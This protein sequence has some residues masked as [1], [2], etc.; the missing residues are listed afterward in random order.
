MN[1][2]HKTRD[3]LYIA[4]VLAIVGCSNSGDP[5]ITGVVSYEGK[6]I[7]SGVINFLPKDGGQPLGGPI[8]A[9]GTFSCSIPPGE[10]TVLISAPA[11][12]PEGWKDGDP[13]PIGRPQV[14]LK[15]ASRATSDLQTHI[16]AET[17]ELNFSLK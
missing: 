1:R 2:R 9:E 6:K 7:T 13:V 4:F 14:P 16:T 8:Q 17:K 15:Y 10:Y 11:A 5:Q 12:V 3:C